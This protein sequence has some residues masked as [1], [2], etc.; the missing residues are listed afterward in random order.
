M[1]SLSPQ[2]A[3][4]PEAA[5]PRELAAP[6]LAALRAELDR[7]DDTLHDLL[8]R[9]ADV[10]AQVGALGA[11]GAVPLRPGREAS[12]IR[13][14]L[15]RHRGDLPAPT[16]VRIWRELLAG[17][18]AQQRPMRITVCEG[19]GGP[20]L[21]AIAREHFGTLTPMT[22]RRTPA[23]A[24]RDVSSGAAT[25]A[26]LPLPTEGE[27]PGAAWWTALLQRD[28]PRV[29]IVARLPFW[30][31]RPEGAPREQALVVS[32]ATPDPSG[33]DRSLLGL[34]LAPD[35]SRARLA[36][37]LAAAGLAPE[38]LILRREAGAA[39][40]MAEVP[41]FVGDGDPRL[42]GLQSVLRPPMVLGAYAVPFGEHG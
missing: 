8:M 20:S 22:E 4:P 26:V 30:A 19:E 18:T 36:A 17:T 12:I 2:P 25:A 34:E 10:V 28:D 23:Q 24:I 40:A 1:S 32:A 27:P 41:G 37:A 29:F 14:L 21:T 33:E 3:P 15:A 5:T 7:V 9:R 35:A 39:V 13:R 38:T 6:R 16:L 31:P 42:A 11:K